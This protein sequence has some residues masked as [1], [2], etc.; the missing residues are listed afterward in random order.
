VQRAAIDGLIAE[1]GGAADE[2][3]EQE[4]LDAAIGPVVTAP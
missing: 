2:V 3:A 4:F 1:A